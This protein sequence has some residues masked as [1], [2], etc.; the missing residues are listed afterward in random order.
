MNT[1][2]RTTPSFEEVTAAFTTLGLDPDLGRIVALQVGI[3]L[4]GTPVTRR[5][6]VLR[7]AVEITGHAEN[8]TRLD[9]ARVLPRT[10]E[11]YHSFGSLSIA[12]PDSLGR[13]G[14]HGPQIVSLS[15]GAETWGLHAEGAAFSRQGDAAAILEQWKTVSDILLDSFADRARLVKAV[16][17]I[18]RFESLIGERGTPGRGF[19]ELV[20]TGRAVAAVQLAQ[21]A[22]IE[23]LFGAKEAEP[24]VVRPVSGYATTRE[25]QAVAAVKA[26]GRVAVRHDSTPGSGPGFY[27]R[28]LRPDGSEGRSLGGV[29]TTEAGAWRKAAIALAIYRPGRVEMTSREFGSTWTANVVGQDGRLGTL[30]RRSRLEIRAL[31]GQYAVFVLQR[32]YLRD[33]P[34]EDVSQRQDGG[35]H[36]TLADAAGYISRYIADY[37]GVVAEDHAAAVEAQAEQQREA[38]GDDCSLDM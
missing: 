12:L 18:D 1:H 28:R 27:A 11:C 17:A 30:E 6:A 31:D 32:D 35:L 29:D 15:P 22:A 2:S 33:E 37:E 3:D 21:A 24:V 23:N 38:V 9:A 4:A 5:E 13:A 26:S 7:R 19:D 20:A 14:C 25:E 8:V 36:A 10:L 16:N 34:P